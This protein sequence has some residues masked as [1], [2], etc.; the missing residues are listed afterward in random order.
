MKCISMNR[1]MKER[2][3]LMCIDENTRVVLYRYVSDKNNIVNIIR[4]II[5]VDKK[6]LLYNIIYRIDD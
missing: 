5:D 2:F 1:K 4:I 6:E 3:I